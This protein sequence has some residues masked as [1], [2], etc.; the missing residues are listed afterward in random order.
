VVGTEKKPHYLLEKQ[1]NMSKLI[2]LTNRLVQEDLYK[3]LNLKV[4]KEHLYTYGNVEHRLVVKTSETSTS[5][6]PYDTREALLA[7]Y[8]EIIEIKIKIKEPLI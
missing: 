7:D 2:R 6:Y 3:I 1:N 4:S 5:Y 8:R